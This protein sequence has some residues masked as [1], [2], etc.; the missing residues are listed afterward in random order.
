MM[1]N[2]TI[3]VSET[4][5]ERYTLVRWVSG[6]VHPVEPFGDYFDRLAGSVA[7]SAPVPCTTC[8]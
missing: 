4:R 8:I 6:L 3:N 5:A 2:D 7:A 1:K